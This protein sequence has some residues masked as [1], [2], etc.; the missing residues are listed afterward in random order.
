VRSTCAPDE[1]RR[2]W[3]DAAVVGRDGGF[4]AELYLRLLGEEELVVERGRPPA[5]M[6]VRTV[7]WTPVA[8]AA[9]A[10]R[11]VG[12]IDADAAAAVVAEYRA[13][14]AMRRP[15]EPAGPGPAVPWPTEDGPAPLGA[16]RVVAVGRSFTVPWGQ[17][18]V[19]Y[20][21]L[22]A[23]TA[24]AVTAIES[25]PGAIGRAAPATPGL[26]PT[27][28]LL[29]DDQGTGTRASYRAD[30]GGLHGERGRLVAERP[31]ARDTR[32]LDL[33]GIRVN[34]TGSAGEPM[35]TVA[36]DEV[37]A[38]GRVQALLAKA[39]IEIHRAGY[40]LV[41]QL[42]DDQRSPFDVLV[43]ALVAAGAMAADD[44]AVTQA[45]LL[46]A[47]RMAWDDPPPPGL[48]EPWASML[49]RQQLSGA[50][51]V[52]PVGVT[53]PALAGPPLAIEA[54][55]AQHT[56]FRLLVTR[57]AGDQP[58]PMSPHCLLDP[59]GVTTPGLPSPGAPVTWWATDDLGRHHLGSSDGIVGL[60]GSIGFAPGI[61]PAATVLRITA[62]TTDRRAVITVPL[63]WA[64]TS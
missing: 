9:G 35:A 8:V 12:A 61:D 38:P 50:D 49:T 7:P 27:D 14:T 19:H 23:M 2:L 56:S 4:D 10:L 58:A 63:A 16:P 26:A 55:V 53:V 54:L 34:L 11:E 6:G 5:G 48:D 45:R 18:I 1:G 21:V 51:G 3:H 46:I 17:I 15:S 62:A 59:L 25:S 47:A 36:V 43:A 44:P 60:H 29:I 42:A 64:V 32:W 40:D 57:L 13:A 33:N 24:V 41:R 37:A 28:A 20:V 22:G 39:L 52:V 31:L 30:L